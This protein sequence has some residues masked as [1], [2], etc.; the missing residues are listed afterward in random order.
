MK[1]ELVSDVRDRLSRESIIKRAAAA[2]TNDV[3]IGAARRRGTQLCRICHQFYYLT[4]NCFRM[5]RI[6]TITKR[7]L[8]E[9]RGIVLFFS[10]WGG[11]GWG[12]RM[13][14]RRGRRWSGGGRVS[15]AHASTHLE[16][17]RC[18]WKMKCCDINPKI[19]CIFDFWHFLGMYGMYVHLGI[20]ISVN[21]IRMLFC[22]L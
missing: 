4:Y 20:S 10:L 14:T 13:M 19:V 22:I 3:G 2:A 16:Q 9:D 17:N 18:V 12:M 15:H 11:C 7:G 21:R 8:W 6:Q 1:R 5:I